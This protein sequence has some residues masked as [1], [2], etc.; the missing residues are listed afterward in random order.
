MS[1]VSWLAGLLPGQEHGR[2]LFGSAASSATNAMLSSALHSAV[3][4]NGGEIN[5]DMLPPRM[6]MAMIQRFD[7][8]GDHVI[9]AQDLSPLMMQE[10][11]HDGNG[12]IDLHDFVSPEDYAALDN[13]DL[14]QYGDTNGDGVIDRSELQ[15][16]L[17]DQGGSVSF[18]DLPAGMRD[19]LIAGLDQ[20]GDG[21]L[22][23]DDLAP[24]TAAFQSTASGR[25]L[26]ASIGDGQGHYSAQELLMWYSTLNRLSHTPPT[27]Q[28]CVDMAHVPQTFQLVLVRNFQQPGQPCVRPADIRELTDSASG[29]SRNRINREIVAG[30]A[31]P[32]G[33]INLNTVPLVLYPLFSPLDTNGD[34]YV[35]LSELNDA[36]IGAVGSQI[37]DNG[38]AGGLV[39]P[40]PPPL[41]SP[42]SYPYISPPA[43]PFPPP[44]PTGGIIVTQAVTTGGKSD[45]GAATAWIIV[46][47]VAGLIALGFCV[48]KV[49]VRR[50]RDLDRKH[51]LDPAMTNDPI[52]NYVPA[53]HTPMVVQPPTQ[54]PQ[55]QVV[56]VQP[57]DATSGTRNSAALA[58]ARAANSPALSQSTV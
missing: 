34:D 58:R 40:H 36:E 46:G 47:V 50:R 18:D 42:P 21:Q 53:V 41:P 9:D 29:V 6:R 24:I 30:F 27:S 5:S 23:S 11:D 45:D 1:M 26:L 19:A 3:Q 20:N 49:F 55:L 7:R 43:P 54:S 52:S 15:H 12:R 4:H 13:A 14:S 17:A 39:P 10:L 48:L 22:N 37:V 38:A 35:D 16:F 2:T 56:Q 25:T 31:G 33:R 32:D 44:T 28:G 57:P 51:I 8:N